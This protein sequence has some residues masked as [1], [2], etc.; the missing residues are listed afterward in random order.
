[1]K[2]LLYL[3]TIILMSFSTIQNEPIER[4]G[5]KGPIEFNKTVFSLAWSE[6]PNANY[7]VQEYLPKNETV[8]KF[9][10]L[11]T[12]NVFVMDVSVENG[13]QQKVNELTK[14]KETDK[15]CNFSVINSPDGK[16]SILDCILSSEKNGELEIVEFIIYRYK[17]IELEN[18]KKAL[19]IYSYS[20]R[21]YGENIT[22]FLKKLGTERTDLLNVMIA[23]ELPN[24]KLNE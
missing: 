10:E 23:K 24:I 7:Y 11:I 3:T 22:P 17:Q 19:L 16:E 21:S 12:V 1:M 6:K 20:K 8:E 14:R 9:N 2:K 5:I 13:I 4:I 18:H 15:V